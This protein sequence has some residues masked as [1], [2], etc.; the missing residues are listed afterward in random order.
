MKNLFTYLSLVSLFVLVLLAVPRVSLAQEAVLDPVCLNNPQATLCKDN[1]TPQTPGNNSILGPNGVVTKAAGI[2]TIVVGIASVLMI[3]I[4]AVQYVI[5]GGDP[6][7]LN[8]AK[9][10]IIYALVGMVITLLSRAI[11][12]FVLNKL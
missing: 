4:G 1:A 12:T 6:A 11:I 9:D 10:T 7:R 5:S 2:I 8:K 3:L